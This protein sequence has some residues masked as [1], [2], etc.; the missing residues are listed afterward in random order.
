MTYYMDNQVELR[1]KARVR[2]NKHNAFNRKLR[3]LILSSQP[4]IDCGEPPD[5]AT[6]FEFDH[7]EGIGASSQRRM[8]D[9]ISKGSHPKRMMAEIPK[10]DVVCPTC[11][12]R[13]T[14]DRAQWKRV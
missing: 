10:C 1:E 3:A 7:R 2:A 5:P 8:S 13:R 14:Y 4:C 11:H 6:P 9:L 12:K